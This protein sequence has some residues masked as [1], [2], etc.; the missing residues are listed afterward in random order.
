MA[1]GSTLKSLLSLPIVSIFDNITFSSLTTVRTVWIGAKLLFWISLK[2][3]GCHGYT[4]LSTYIKSTQWRDITKYSGRKIQ[5]VLLALFGIS[6]S[7]QTIENWLTGVIPT[8]SYSGHYDYDEQVVR[9]KGDQAYR[10]TLF[11]VVLNIPVAEDISYKL[12]ANC[13][14]TFLEENL[15]DQPIYSITTD[16]RKWYRHIIK[17]LKAVHQLCGFHFI[18]RVTADADYY[19]KRKSV[20]DAEKMR[21]AILVSLIREVFRSFTKR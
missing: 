9:I 12:N 1:T 11:D 14:E 3:P 7:H 5:Q 15:K 17:K 10:L 19:F 16:D 6:P 13:V 20:S 4:E 8:F 21:I 2:L 18:K